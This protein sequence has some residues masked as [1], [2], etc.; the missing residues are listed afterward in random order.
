MFEVT[1]ME[2]IL[3]SD[4]L[5]RQLQ[6][7]GCATVRDMSHTLPPAV[8]EGFL[9]HLRDTQSGRLDADHNMSLCTCNMRIYELRDATLM[10]AGDVVLSNELNQ[11]GCLYLLRH[12]S[13]LIA[14]HPVWLPIF[15]MSTLHRESPAFR[16]CRLEMVMT[17]EGQPIP[18]PPRPTVVHASAPTQVWYD[19]LDTTKNVSYACQMELQGVVTKWGFET[20]VREV[21]YAA[22][23]IF[24]SMSSQTNHLHSLDITVRTVPHPCSPA[25]YTNTMHDRCLITGNYLARCLI[26]IHNTVDENNRSTKNAVDIVNSVLHEVAHCIAPCQIQPHI[27]PEHAH[28]HHMLWAN[29]NAYLIAQFHTASHGPA[30][31]EMAGVLR[32]HRTTYV[33]AFRVFPNCRDHQMFSNI[34]RLVRP[35][36]GERHARSVPPNQLAE[37]I[38]EAMDI[39]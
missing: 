33:Q 31:T 12:V 5:T 28:D 6:H 2:R 29:A 27:T 39:V 25:A 10:E 3:Y 9:R 24:L 38:K 22:Y 15:P 37:C 35:H 7:T 1:D 17:F 13:P 23:S 21:A 26:V 30:L 4:G 14:P 34:C 16:V 36:T 11:G 8:R 18:K 20:I 32:K 19:H